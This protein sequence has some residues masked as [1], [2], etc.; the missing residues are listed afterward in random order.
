MNTKIQIMKDVILVCA[1]ND[2]LA[3]V[4]ITDAANCDGHCE[5]RPSVNNYICKCTALH[6]FLFEG[7]SH[8]CHCTILQYL[9]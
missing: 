7:R 5:L 4:L 6:L 9:M 1:I 2:S 8:T 3:K